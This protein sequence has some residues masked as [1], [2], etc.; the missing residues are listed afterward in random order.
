MKILSGILLPFLIIGALPAGLSTAS[1]AE[2]QE[3]SSPDS[4][5]PAQA[6][7]T[8]TVKIDEDL[9]QRKREVIRRLG[10]RRSQM[11]DEDFATNGF[12]NMGFDD[13][14]F[15]GSE[16]PEPR[17][18]DPGK[19][20]SMMGVRPTFTVTYYGPD[21][22]E[23]SRAT[24]PGRY[25]AR[26]ICDLGDGQLRGVTRNLYRAP[27]DAGLSAMP[28]D[29]DTALRL[30][31]EHE[32]GHNWTEEQ[33]PPA[34]RADF[35][36]D[37]VDQN[38]GNTTSYNYFVI[39]PADPGTRE[40]WP[41]LVYL[42]GAGGIKVKNLE[43]FQKDPFFDNFTGR[44]GEAKR[45]FAG[46]IVV[47]QAR[48]AW[49]APA[50]IRLLD[51]LES[52]LPIDEK[53]VAVAGFSMGSGGIK[54]LA[55]SH[56]HRLSA[57]VGVAGGTLLPEQ[58]YR[59]KNL[60]MWVFYGEDDKPHRLPG[61]LERLRHMKQEGVPVRWTLIPGADH[62]ESRNLAFGNPELYQWLLEQ[63]GD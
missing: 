19:V 17:F 11:S 51:E 4:T 32:L 12:V 37:E 45:P 59:V 54:S 3:P 63:R 50:L 28:T 38:Q 1:A 49:S 36:W 20:A 16:L 6:Q 33:M 24:E 26:I 8:G 18:E 40:E 34:S 48:G 31:F 58:V 21:A 52:T 13:Y 55:L 10:W 41:L 42:H 56:P 57:V 27:D 47:P 2:A 25:G 62:V 61:N 29:E 46:Y 5:Q 23:T 7:P 39:P 35:F 43:V 60:P 22:R 15:Q 53:Q 9:A 30:A 44:E 14:V